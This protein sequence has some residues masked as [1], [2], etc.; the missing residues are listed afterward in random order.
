MRKSFPY[1]VA[2]ALLVTLAPAYAANPSQ[3]QTGK[4]AVHKDDGGLTGPA[5]PASTG[6]DR[7]TNVLMQGQDSFEALPNPYANPGPR[8]IS[9]AWAQRT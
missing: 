4:M 7:T 3:D 8:M 2:A 9:D 5:S 6:G 1:A